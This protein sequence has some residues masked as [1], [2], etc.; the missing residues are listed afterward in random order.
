[1]H[2]INKHKKSSQELYIDCVKNRLNTTLL[3]Y[4]E[5]LENSVNYLS[6]RNTKNLVKRINNKL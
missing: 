3:N 6:K 2:D 5:E 4:C 1:M